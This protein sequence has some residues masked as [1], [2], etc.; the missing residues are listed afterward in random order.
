MIAT[1]TAIPRPTYTATP[2]A[3]P[4]A[5]AKPE[6]TSLGNEAYTFLSTFLENHNRRE[7]G[8]EGERSAALAIRDELDSL[9]YM[10]TVE[11]FDVGY[12][13]SDVSFVLQTNA[14]PVQIAAES[15]ALQFSSHGEATGEL[16]YLKQALEGQV[17]SGGL[18][19]K[20][21]LIER[22]VDFFSDKA[23]RAALAGAE[24]AIIFNHSPSTFTGYLVERS[25]IPTVGISGDAGQELLGAMDR[26]IVESSVVVTGAEV[27]SMNV[28]AEKRGTQRDGGVVYLTT[29]LDAVADV[30]GANDN[31]SGIA[32]LMTIARHVSARQYPFTVKVGFFG[33]L[34]SSDIGTDRAGGRY[35]VN[36]L[37]ATD[38][39]GIRAVVNM[40]MSG[41]G[42]VLHFG[43]TPVN[44]SIM[45]RIAQN[46]SIRIQEDG[47]LER[48]DAQAFDER[49]INTITLTGNDYTH[50][51][52]A[53]DTIDNIDRTLLGQT[54][55]LTLG[56]LDMLADER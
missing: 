10:T 2:S 13:P 53:T 33:S 31:G 16:V 44:R 42:D 35:H 38:V 50:H 21:A 25:P 9:G 47:G 54:V 12:L 18:E 17:P 52:I 41:S 4:T 56:F 43:G 1:P 32:S 8:T 51:H 30:D 55:K 15:T 7:S 26:G 28:I 19:G 34:H 49:E 20:I 46:L 39:S 27:R 23:N 22:G 48:T 6:H 24:A 37:D 36:Q 45:N 3:T 29:Y 5:T 40:Y 14:G 11:G